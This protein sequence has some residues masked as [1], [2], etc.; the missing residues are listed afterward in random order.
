LAISETVVG[1]KAN[2][3]HELL[4]GFTHAIKRGKHV[5]N[6]VCDSP[7]FVQ[8]RANGLFVPNEIND[9]CCINECFVCSW[10]ERQRSGV[11]LDERDTTPKAGIS[12]HLRARVD[13]ITAKSLALQFSH[14]ETLAS[15]NH[16]H[17]LLDRIQ[18]QVQAGN[19]K[20]I[21]LDERMMRRQ[22]I[23]KF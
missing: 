16:Q 18:Q 6:A 23:P 1:K 2:A 11:R 3:C 19:I 9:T 4:L 5:S 17:R 21:I 12:N 10:R 7:T 14:N 22:G 20:E 15:A 8:D 13:A